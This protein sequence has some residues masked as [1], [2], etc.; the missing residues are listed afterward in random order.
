MTI[1]VDNYT[2]KIVGVV[3]QDT[4][5]TIEDKTSYI[6]NTDIEPQQL[7]M[8]NYVD[9]K[10]V[11]NAVLDLKYKNKVL[12]DT[13][14]SILNNKAYEYGYD[15]IITA[16]SYAGY[17]NAYQTE[18]IMFLRWRSEVWEYIHTQD[19]ANKTIEEIVAGIPEL[20]A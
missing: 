12:N 11:V 2:N 16:V 9:G 4:T 19:I 17:E 18:G 1:I 8:Y 15:S 7:L 3:T 10:L 5:I 14:T 20:G 6:I 13:V